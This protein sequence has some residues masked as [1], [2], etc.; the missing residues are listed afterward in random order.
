MK[1]GAV[2]RR[3]SLATVDRKW[4]SNVHLNLQPILAVIHIYISKPPEHFLTLFCK[5][6]H[7]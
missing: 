5:H 4:A 7:H 3:G 6:N 2:G 1:A